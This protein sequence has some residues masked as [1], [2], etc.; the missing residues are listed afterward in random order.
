MF[1][2]AQFLKSSIK[3]KENS[4]ILKLYIII[5]LFATHNTSPE[6]TSIVRFFQFIQLNVCVCTVSSFRIFGV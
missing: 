5:Y 1:I 2:N 4:V 3:S 6:K